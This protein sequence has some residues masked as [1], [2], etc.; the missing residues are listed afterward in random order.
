MRQNLG[1]RA[2]SKM[3]GQL[4]F[5]QVFS[6]ILAL[7]PNHLSSFPLVYSCRDSQVRSLEERSFRVLFVNC[8]TETLLSS[9]KTITVFPFINAVVLG[10]CL[11]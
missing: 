9:K 4:W 10:G 8:S 1:S 3:I 7:K 11:D 2:N 6:T 5:L